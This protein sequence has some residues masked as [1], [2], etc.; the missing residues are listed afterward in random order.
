M[1]ASL[2]CCTA[3]KGG[4][5]TGKQ[6]KAVFLTE[7]YLSL[8]NSHM[9]PPHRVGLRCSLQVDMEHL[10]PYLAPG[11]RRLR[12]HNFQLDTFP[13]ATEH[14]ASLTSLHLSRAGLCRLPVGLEQLTALRVLDLSCNVGLQLE[15]EDVE[16]LT[17]LSHLRTLDLTKWPRHSSCSQKSVDVWT[18]D[19]HRVL[20]RIRTHCVDWICIHDV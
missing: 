1:S 6:G 11:L 7:V 18:S 3:S 8:S 20:R 15:A 17:V 4:L 13:D 10:L 2:L 14:L 19:S 16:V 9:R 12:L 5:F